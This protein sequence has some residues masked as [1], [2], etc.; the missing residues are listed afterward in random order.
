MC[1]AKINYVVRHIAIMP[2]VLQQCD[3][4][5]AFESFKECYQNTEYIQF[6]LEAICTGDATTIVHYRKNYLYA[7]SSQNPGK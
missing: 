1:N 7:L 5:L 6:Y 3:S 4:F 2:H